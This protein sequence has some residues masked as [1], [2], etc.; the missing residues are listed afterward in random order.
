MYPG[1]VRM[2]AYMR[3]CVCIYVSDVDLCH[4][5]NGLSYAEHIIITRF[6]DLSND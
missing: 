5:M 4:R 3:V 6:N 2:Y 1:Y